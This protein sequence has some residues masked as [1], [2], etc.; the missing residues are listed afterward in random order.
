MTTNP[1]T[2]PQAFL[3]NYWQKKPLL[4]SQIWPDFESPVSVQELRWLAEETLVEARCVKK[5]ADGE[6]LVANGPFEP[7]ALPDSHEANW[8]LLVQAADHWVPEVQALLAQ[9]RWLPTWRMDDIMVSL[10]NTGGGVGPHYDQYDVFLIQAQGTRTWE[11]GTVCDD[12][13][14]M[15]VGSG[16]KQLQQMEVTQT[17]QVSAGDILYI[18]PGVSHNGVATSNDCITLSVGFRAPS[19]GELLTD[20]FAWQAEKTRDSDRFG[21]ADR[22][23]T[24]DPHRITDWDITQLQTILRH[25]ADDTTELKRWFGSV[26]TEPKYPELMPED[27]GHSLQDWQEALADADS[28]C[29]EPASRIAVD[30]VHLFVDARVYL[31]S[32]A[33]PALEHLLL[34]KAP[35]DAKI[36]LQLFGQSEGQDHLLLTSLNQGTLY[37]S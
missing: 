8:T 36:A 3:S 34:E 24:A 16:L 17:H 12:N 23:T 15:K 21:D 37:I 18:P 30:E 5:T 32:N 35:I 9:F 4:M 19:H 20:F 13:T 33:Q 26:M 2:D 27:L 10:S 14:P 7:E 28:L 22:P 1:F 25:Y 11:V 29:V 6:W 31:R